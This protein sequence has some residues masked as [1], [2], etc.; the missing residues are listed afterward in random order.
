MTPT[1]C[2]VDP[3]RDRFPFLSREQTPIA[4]CTIDRPETDI[5][6]TQALGREHGIIE[7]YY[8]DGWPTQRP[9]MLGLTG[10]AGVYAYPTIDIVDL[11]DSLDILYAVGIPLAL[12]V[13]TYRQ[14]A[15]GPP[16]RYSWTEQQV[17]DRLRECWDL[18]CEFRIE[19]IIGFAGVRMYEGEIVDGLA[20]WPAIRK[21][22]EAMRSACGGGLTFPR[23]VEVTE[24]ARFF[25]RAR[26]L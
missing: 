15:P 16:H 26:M 18:V 10:Y 24:L 13:A 5:P 25:P 19:V 8:R 7:V 3:P 9:D 14:F 4:F 22:W 1:I 12:N 20:R 6:G 11:H 2:A 23:R 17:V 21:A